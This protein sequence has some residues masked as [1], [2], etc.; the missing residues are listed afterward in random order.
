MPN[1]ILLISSSRDQKLVESLLPAIAE[2][3][4]GVTR[5]SM[6][7]TNEKRIRLPGGIRISVLVLTGNADGSNRVHREVRA[8]PKRMPMLVLRYAEAKVSGSLRRRVQA[9]RS[10]V[11]SNPATETEIAGAVAMMVEMAAGAEPL[12]AREVTPPHRSRRSQSSR[13]RR[14]KRWARTG[15][16]AGAAAAIAWYFARGSMVGG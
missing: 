2:R 8:L 4:L 5:S 10:V 7:N 12:V 14:L 16:I 9:A 11:L 6:D 3:G 1:E 13:R 15:L